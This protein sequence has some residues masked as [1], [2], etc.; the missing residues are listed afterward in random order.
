MNIRAEKLVKKYGWMT[1]LDDVSL[2]IAAGQIVAVLGSNG[3][4]KTTLLN[5]LGGMILLD[6]GQVLLDGEL[7]T[8]GRDDLRRRFGFIPDSPPIPRGWSP[9]RLI[10]SMLKLYETAPHGIEDRVVE[11]LRRLDLLS[12]ANWRFRQLSRGQIYKAVLA[13]LV[14][15]DPELWLVDEPFASGMDPRGL[16]CFKEYTRDAANRGH[17][18]IYTTQI[19]EVAETFADRICLLDRGR[20][21]ACEKPAALI[22]Q[23]KLE[24]L[25]TPLREAPGI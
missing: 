25:V 8:P 18:I 16:S 23:A 22:G 9:L 6:G 7:Y 12:V 5:A 2:D 14:A 21:L 20:V 1:A 3:A 11:L 13:A 17:T 4:G 10:G 24:A 19:V 15:V